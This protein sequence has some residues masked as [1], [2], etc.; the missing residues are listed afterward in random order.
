M[1]VV[2]LGD[3]Q[4][5]EPNNSEIQNPVRPYMVEY[6]WAL[7]IGKLGRGILR[8]T[9]GSLKGKQGTTIINDY[10]HFSFLRYQVLL[11]DRPRVEVAFEYKDRIHKDTIYLTSK[12]INFGKR[13]YWLCSCGYVAATLYHR[14]GYFGWGCRNCR[15][16]LRYKLTT[17]NKNTAPGRI[18]Y[19]INRSQK[20]KELGV[21]FRGKPLSYG[22]KPTHRFQ[23]YVR[24][25]LKWTV[26]PAVM[27]QAF[28]Q[29]GR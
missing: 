8:T 15:L 12:Q 16:N 2:Q 20:I 13:P 19:A 1:A 29:L 6:C 25:K 17:I 7:P 24:N 27:E 18:L 3:V 9:K 11:D 21:E 14:P 22:G 10:D 26:T 4:S 5:M 23:A 28:A